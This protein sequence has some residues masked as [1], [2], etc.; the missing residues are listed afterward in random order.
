[1]LNARQMLIIRL[2][3]EGL[4]LGEIARR[5]EM[6][7]AG[8]MAEFRAALRALQDPEHPGGWR[9]PASTPAAR[10]RRDVGE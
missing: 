4:P 5:T 9:H 2:V 7:R 1:M 6:S 3:V 8:A 10:S